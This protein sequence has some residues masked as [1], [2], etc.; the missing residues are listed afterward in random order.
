MLG[1]CRLLHVPLQARDE[2]KA[3]LNLYSGASLRSAKRPEHRLLQRHEANHRK[4][5]TKPGFHKND[6][7]YRNAHASKLFNS[8]S[9]FKSS[10]EIHFV[11]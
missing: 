1:Q 5:A 3:Q 4:N 7:I 11:K 8:A 10:F 9:A 2:D 6:Y